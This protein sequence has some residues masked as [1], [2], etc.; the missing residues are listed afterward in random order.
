MSSEGFPVL[1]IAGPTAVGKSLTA[2]YL[3][4]A[5]DAPVLSADAMQVYRGMDIGTAKTPVS[6]RL[7]PLLLTDIVEPTESYSAALYQNDARTLIDHM[8]SCKQH[9]V[10]CGGTG[11][12]INAVLDA[13]EFPSGEIDDVR[14]AHY[15]QLAIKL[16][17]QGI[18]EYLVDRDPRSAAV[19]HPN[20]TR[21]VIRALE[22]LDEGI[23]YS[24]QLEA[25]G[26]ISEYY[27]SMR[28]SLCMERSRLYERIDAR[29]DT[30][31]QQGLVDEVEQLARDGAKDSL[32]SRQAIGYKEIFDYLDGHSCLE[33]AVALIKQR[34]RRYAKRQISWFKKDVRYTPVDMDEMNPQQAAKCIYDL[35]IRYGNRG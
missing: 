30:M 35:Y 19:I 24:D 10:M 25:F 34:S 13:M 20:N 31:I 23:H 27:P 11:L 28:F 17:T 9:V 18:Y 6:E 12:Y 3:A 7:V 1:V 32:T 14:R 8:R 2:D 4:R 21:R 15:Q 29:V 16:G 22:M 26:E 33:D 5:L